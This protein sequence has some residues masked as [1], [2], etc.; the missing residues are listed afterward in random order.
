MQLNLYVRATSRLR[1][2]VLLA[3][4]RLV[5]S[6]GWIESRRR[7]EDAHEHAWNKLVRMLSPDLLIVDVDEQIQGL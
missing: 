7:I 4:I 1:L 3:M 2:I 6:S 5:C